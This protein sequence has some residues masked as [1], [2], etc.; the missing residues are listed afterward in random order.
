ML[1]PEPTS[2]TLVDQ[3]ISEL[4]QR[5]SSGELAVGQRLP[6]ERELIEDLGVSRTVLRE[7][8]SGLEALGML[9][10]RS[11]RGRYVATNQSSEQ[12]QALVS[13]WLFHHREQI[14][15]HDEILAVLEARIISQMSEDDA[16]DAARRARGSIIDQMAAVERGD[17]QQ[18]A[19]CDFDFHQ[20]LTSY[21]GNA[22]MRALTSAIME[23]LRSGLIALHS[24]PEN[25]ERSL[26]S[27]EAIIEALVRGDTASA[28]ALDL[29]HHVEPRR[30]PADDPNRAGS[31][32]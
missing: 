7:A 12:S 13:A 28:A 17:A 5:I 10:S 11:T 21:T 14:S 20:V 23:Q 15:E 4:R 18:A 3:V 1:V 25:A 26:A 24:I 22:T 2:H 9:E 31:A 6:P 27:H 29:A 16:F 8:L 19:A 30:F 32:N